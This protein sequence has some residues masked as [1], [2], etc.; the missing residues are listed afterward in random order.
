MS[1]EGVKAMTVAPPSFFL[2][3]HRPATIPRKLGMVRGKSSKIYWPHR[4]AW[5]RT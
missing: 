4:L 5:F 2:G 3:R 1:D